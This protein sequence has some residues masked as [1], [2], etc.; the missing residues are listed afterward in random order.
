[1]KAKRVEEMAREDL[2][3]A[4]ERA[5]I[6]AGISVQEAW[7]LVVDYTLLGVEIPPEF[8]RAVMAV[9]VRMGW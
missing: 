7:E 8:R 2:Y 4:L 9:K 6:L 3:E 1:M 5:A